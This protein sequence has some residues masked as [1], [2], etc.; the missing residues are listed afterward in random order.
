MWEIE[1]TLN[2]ISIVIVGRHKESCPKKYTEL[3]TRDRYCQLALGAVVLSPYLNESM[4][5][6]YHGTPIFL[7]VVRAFFLPFFPSFLLN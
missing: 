7:L 2:V 6:I 3:D 5:F 1:S 4:D